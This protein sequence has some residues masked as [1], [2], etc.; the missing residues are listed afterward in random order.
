[1]VKKVTKG[2]KGKGK[3][4]EVTKQS[5]KA[6][7]TV[8]SPT[9]I[10]KAKSGNVEATHGKFSVQQIASVFCI[11]IIFYSADNPSAKY[12]QSIGKDVQRIIYNMWDGIVAK[13]NSRWPFWCYEKPLLDDEGKRQYDGN[14][15]LISELDAE[16]A[17]EEDG[18]MEYVQL[19]YPSN[20]NDTYEGKKKRP[21]SISR[22][23]QSYWMMRGIVDPAVVSAFINA[24]AA[25][26]C[27][28]TTTRPTTRSFDDVSEKTAMSKW[29]ADNKTATSNADIRWFFE[30]VCAQTAQVDED[31]ELILDA[32]GN[33]QG[34]N[35]SVKEDWDKV[36]ALYQDQM[37]DT[38]IF[39][40]SEAGKTQDDF[41]QHTRTLLT[42]HPALQLED[43]AIASS[44]KLPGKL[45]GA[46]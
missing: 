45:F 2:G 1:M 26:F 43:G 3:A 12:A 40:A 8:A 34:Y 5:R 4:Q 41:D 9:K 44:F 33:P 29:P 28:P 27:R 6:I 13:T 35:S 16:V 46:T 15:R 37:F 42:S 25:A 14:G 36:L 38:G 18:P 20:G 23:G 32:D 22:T 39:S 21:D 19:R 30:A 10:K 31:D 11:V 7:Q 17:P 24:L